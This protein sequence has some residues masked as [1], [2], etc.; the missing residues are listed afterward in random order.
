MAINHKDMHTALTAIRPLAEY[1]LCVPDNGDQNDVYQ[2][3]NWLDQSQ[4]KPTE[5]ELIDAVPAQD[6]KNTRAAEYPKL[7]NQLDQIGKA[8][9]Y[10]KDNGTDIGP[11]GEE[12]VNTLQD[13]KTNN[14]LL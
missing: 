8:L 1:Q 14:P 9:K 4:I 13:V 6:I 10:L 12:L 11:D 3:L 7:G 5:Q 2:Y